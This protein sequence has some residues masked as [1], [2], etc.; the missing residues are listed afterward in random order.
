MSG[1]HGDSISRRFD[2]PGVGAQRQHRQRQLPHRAVPRRQLQRRGAGAGA[3]GG[4]GAA[5]ARRERHPRATAPY[6]A[7]YRYIEAQCS[8]SPA[9]VVPAGG[10]VV[11]RRLNIQPKGRTGAR[12]LPLP[13]LA[14]AQPP[15]ADG[16]LDARAGKDADIYND[17]IIYIT[18]DERDGTVGEP[19]SVMFTKLVMCGSAQPCSPTWQR[20]PPPPSPP[21]RRRL[22]RRV[23]PQALT[24]SGG[25]TGKSQSKRACRGV[26]VR[27]RWT[28]PGAA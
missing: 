11:P 2:S 15:P 10:D 4:G 27:S 18:Q 12:G 6:A 7:Q 20:C 3:G 19:Q 14:L 8:Q 5:P 23:R 17:Q 13:A 21:A 22:R 26:F 1:H 25:C 28:E 9:G 24:Q 16:A